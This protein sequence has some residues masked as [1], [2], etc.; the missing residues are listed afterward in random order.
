MTKRS[1]VAEPATILPAEL[2]DLYP[3]PQAEALLTGVYR[4]ILSDPTPSRERLV[5]VGYPAASVDPILR[6]L[7][8]HRLID[9]AFD[10]QIAPVPPDA[11]RPGEEVSVMQ[12]VAPA[13][14]AAFSVS[15]LSITPLVS[16]AADVSDNSPRTV[17][18]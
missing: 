12:P 4:A 3:D 2:T 11:A 10:G 14:D 1:P 5:D 8:R 6:V 7:V 15:P 16:D 17:T 18:T 9:M 13:I